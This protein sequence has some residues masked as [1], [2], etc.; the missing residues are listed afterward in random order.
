MFTCRYVL[1]LIYKTFSNLAYTR[2]G[3]GAHPKA[4]VY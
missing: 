2:L 4:G 3:S 1:C